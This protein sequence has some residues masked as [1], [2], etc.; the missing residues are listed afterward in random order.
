M[1]SKPKASSSGVMGLL[2]TT[3]YGMAV[4]QTTV[5]EKIVWLPLTKVAMTRTDRN[6]MTAHAELR[7]PTSA[8]YLSKSLP[9]VPIGQIGGPIVLPIQIMFGL[10]HYNVRSL[11]GG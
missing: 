6:G 1:T 5:G 9:N 10:C 8:A 4:N 7:N 11:A 3:P 2:R